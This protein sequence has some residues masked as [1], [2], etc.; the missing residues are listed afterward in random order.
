MEP[1]WAPHKGPKGP[2]RG[3]KGV[4]KGVKKGSFGVP[5][6]DLRGSQDLRGPKMRGPEI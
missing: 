6:L 5:T 2:K 1:L 3:P 4:Q